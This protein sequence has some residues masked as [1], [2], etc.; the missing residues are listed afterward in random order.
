MAVHEP[1]IPAREVLRFGG[2]IVLRLL[3]AM[4]VGLVVLKAGHAF[5]AWSAADAVKYA[6]LVTAG[7]F[8]VSFLLRP[9]AYPEIDYGPDSDV[10]LIEDESIP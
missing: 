5:L 10:S 9:V 3:L 6:E 2:H 8:A 1:G 4:L 7:L